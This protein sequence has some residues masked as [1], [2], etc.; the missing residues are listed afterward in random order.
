MPSTRVIYQQ[1]NVFVGPPNSTGFFYSSGNSGANLVKQLFR[2]QS[3]NRSFNISRQDIN[4]LGQLARIDAVITEPPT[5]ALE[6][7]WYSTNLNNESGIG[8][9]VNGPF[10]CISGILTKANDDRNIFVSRSPQGQDDNTYAANGNGRICYGLGNCFL[11][12]YSIEGSVGGLATASASFEGFNFFSYGAAS[13][14]SPAILPF[15]GTSVVGPTFQ[16]PVGVSGIFGQASAI[17]FGEMVVDISN[18]N[19]IGAAVSDLKIQSFNLNLPVARESISVLGSLYPSSKEVTVPVNASLTVETIIGDSATGNLGQVLC[20]DGNYT[21][22]VSLY[23]P[24]C[25]GITGQLAARYTLVGAKLDSQDFS[26]GIGPA[27][28]LSL[29][30]SVQLGGA[31][32]T[33]GVFISGAID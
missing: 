26:M 32:S 4:E 28:T 13:G 25:P 12:N 3:A 18:V 2:V 27:E 6:L 22:T 29:P 17:R 9:S 14:V 10:S 1:E 30:F 11:S 24:A 19:V 31:N 16:L 23:K 8:L 20:N 21:I 33:V 5:V 7:S 15:N